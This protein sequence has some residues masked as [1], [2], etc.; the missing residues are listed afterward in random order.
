MPLL[1]GD[2]PLMQSL[3]TYIHP[4]WLMSRLGTGLEHLGYVLRISGR[5]D[6]SKAWDET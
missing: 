6:A 1:A 4:P 2:V 5:E 3:K